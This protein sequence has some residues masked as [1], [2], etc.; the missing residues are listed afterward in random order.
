MCRQ[1]PERA[2][3]VGRGPG[4]SVLPR[5]RTERCSGSQEFSLSRPQP[6]RWLLG[7]VDATGCV[8]KYNLYFISVSGTSCP[9][10]NN[11]AV[12]GGFSDVISIAGGTN[13]VTERGYY[14]TRL[15]CVQTSRT[16]A[17]PGVGLEFSETQLLPL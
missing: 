6:L 5:G 15:R 2:W 14:L 3:P 10:S 12:S 7:V 4:T 17:L 13:K 9:F 1:F 8:R 16:G 11:F